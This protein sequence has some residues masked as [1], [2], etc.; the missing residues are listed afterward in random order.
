MTGLRNF[1][2]ITRKR[3][4]TLLEMGYSRLSEL[5]V[6][7]ITVIKFGI[8]SGGGNSNGPLCQLKSCQLLYNCTK[9]CI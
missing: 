8:N 5:V 6:K 9:N 1:N 4:L 3:V 2:K 7:R